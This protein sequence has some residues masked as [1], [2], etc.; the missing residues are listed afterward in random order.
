M[1]KETLKK[2][3][4]LQYKGMGRKECGRAF[5]IGLI[6]FVIFYLFALIGIAG[7]FGLVCWIAGIMW[8]VKT[9]QYKKD[10]KRRIKKRLQELQ[11]DPDKDYQAY[12]KVVKEEE[13]NS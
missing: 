6:G 8:V 11:I 1:E 4:W 2:K 10:L 9:I 5:W 3:K 12:Y 7:I 13:N